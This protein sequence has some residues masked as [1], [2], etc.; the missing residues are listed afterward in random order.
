MFGGRY[1]VRAARLSMWARAVASGDGKARA[2][3]EDGMEE[4]TGMVDGTPAREKARETRLEKGERAERP[5]ERVS[6]DTATGAGNMVIDFLSAP[7]KR[8][9][10]GGMV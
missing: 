1:G 2:N 8:S 9:T 4:R 10:C 5:E 6:L 7:R 3:R